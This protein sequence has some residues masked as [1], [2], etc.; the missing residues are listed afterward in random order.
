[1]P[2]CISDS[3][4]KGFRVEYYHYDWRL[5]L[6]TLGKQL[7]KYVQMQKENV[8]IVA[9]S[10]G[11]LVT[12]AALKAGA[13]RIDKVVMLGT[14]NQGSFAPVEVLQGIN[15]NVVLA[16]KLDQ[17]HTAEELTKT[18]FSTF[19]SV[20]EMLPRPE[21]YDRLDLLD[22]S[23]WPNG[24]LRPLS[25]RL[26]GVTKTWQQMTDQDS[27][28]YLIAG[29]GQK[30]VTDLSID[31]NKQQFIYHT[32]HE[33]DGTVP[34]RMCQLPSINDRTWY[35]DETHTGLLRSEIVANAVGDLLGRS[36]TD[37]LP[38]FIDPSSIRS[39]SDSLTDQDFL[40]NPERS[41]LLDSRSGAAIHPADLPLILEASLSFS[42]LPARETLQAV[43][44]REKPMP[45]AAADNPPTAKPDP[46]RLTSGVTFNQ[47]VISRDHQSNL[48]LELFNG[49]LFDVHY[50]ALVIG[51]FANVD[52]SG[53]ANTLDA[54]TDG[55]VTELISRRML[56]ADVG[57]VFVMPTGRNALKADYV[58][59]AGLGDYA[60]F[61]EAPEA[62]LQTIS[63]NIL[64]TLMTCGVDEFATLIYG[65]ASGHSMRTSV[66]SLIRGYLDALQALGS[67]NRSVRFRRVALC[68]YN[69]LKYAELKDEA[70][71]LGG[72]E[73]CK[74]IRLKL[75]EA[76]FPATA[77]H[78]AENVDDRVKCLRQRSPE[79]IVYLTAS[80]E[81]PEENSDLWTCTAS[82]LGV[83]SKAAIV[84]SVRGFRKNELSDQLAMLPNGSQS[85]TMPKMLST[86]RRIRDIL[87]TDNFVQMIDLLM[88]QGDH[89]V[90]VTDAEASRIPWE[91]LPL[92]DTKSTS[93]KRVSPYPCLNAGVSRRFQMDQTRSLAK[94]MEQRQQNEILEVLLIVNPTEDLDGAEAEGDLVEDALSRL[95]LVRVTRLNRSQATRSAVLKAFGSGDYD[96]VHYAGH[97][98]FD[99][100]DRGRCGLLCA[101][102][103]GAT[104]F[105]V[106]T[107][108]DLDRLTHL[109]SLVFFNA[110]ESG[111]TR[112]NSPGRLLRPRL[113]GDPQDPTTEQF[114]LR[115]DAATVHTGVCESLL[116]GGISQFIGTYWP[117]GDFPAKAFAST[118]YAELLSGKTVRECVLAGRRTIE[119]KIDS[120]N[121]MHYG[122]PAFVVKDRR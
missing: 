95:D 112:K 82:L 38:N 8:S 7:A 87:L 50:R 117:V 13:T 100:N 97:G 27:R 64:R 102:S 90:V 19:P 76:Y 113:S 32:T 122:D 23:Q 20:Y 48:E 96:V 49:N 6:T 114:E 15:S 84:R 78:I 43:R 116:R 51:I 12:R 2:I 24:S 106:L 86:G 73:L 111:R 107:G 105:D 3:E 22:P 92:I 83:G 75:H 4:F 66:E 104:P 42:S 36:S 108:S 26:N 39:S 5:S 52:P 44:D 72:T 120:A 59:F 47:T 71:R 80:I 115:N 121:Y 93:D 41:E 54:L 34:L 17:Q 31:S 11:G 94:F 67:N 118:F 68:E 77:K 62:V 110:C 74:D 9:H 69:K 98:F 10:M 88:T 25:S 55:A 16:D 85:M 99:P 29:H 81:Q 21:V 18:V 60:K 65:S 63:C 53:P 46:S 91:I 35:A 14:P 56:N 37:R 1:M 101:S 30:T 89:L 40:D 61:A 57:Q 28:L 119:Q 109:P 45:D 103:S 33:G 58:V 79:S 70:Y